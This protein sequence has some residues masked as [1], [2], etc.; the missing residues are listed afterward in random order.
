MFFYSH[1]LE[2]LQIIKINK[3]DYSITLG[4]TQPIIQWTMLHRGLLC[5]TLTLNNCARVYL[6]L[7]YIEAEYI[8]LFMSYY[9]NR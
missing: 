1:C 3:D 6:M 4:V 8:I 5:K 7:K 2:I 9:D